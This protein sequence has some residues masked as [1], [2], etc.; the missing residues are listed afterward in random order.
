MGHDLSPVEHAAKSS[1]LEDLK[2]IAGQSM[3]DK[4]HGLKKVQVASDSEEGL[5]HGL[6]KAHEI[7]SGHEQHGME[8]AAE[9]GEEDEH[10][11]DGADEHA[12]PTSKETEHEGMDSGHQE[13]ELHAGGSLEPEEE[14]NHEE[15]KPEH[16]SPDEL[17]E[18]IEKLHKM[19][20]AKGAVHKP[21]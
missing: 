16:M 4:L 7:V 20:K 15:K 2:N 8:E 18:H 1:V 13:D 12:F 5:K 21:Y 9:G 11:M 10:D 3:S 19:R 17:D 14:M 6:E